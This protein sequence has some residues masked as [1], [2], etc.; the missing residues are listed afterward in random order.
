[1]CPRQGSSPPA[2]PQRFS[3]L[4]LVRKGGFEP[5]RSCERQPLKLVRLPVPPLSLRR[6]YESRALRPESRLKFEL[7]DPEPDDGGASTGA[8]GA[9]V[10]AGVVAGAG[11]VTGAGPE[12]PPMS[13]R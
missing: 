6:A 10:G 7:Y 5:P 13:D 8:D 3:D 2:S 11:V 1:M 12:I 9:G 4:R